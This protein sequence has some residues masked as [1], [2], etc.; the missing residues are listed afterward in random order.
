MLFSD[1]LSV[2]QREVG[3]GLDIVVIMFT[4]LL[5]GFQHQL[6]INSVTNYP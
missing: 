3:T 2:F 5:N 6:N 4:V 1:T